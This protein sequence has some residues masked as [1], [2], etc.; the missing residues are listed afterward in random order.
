MLC[1]VQLISKH[2][3]AGT[4]L[5]DPNER[6]EQ[7]PAAANKQAEPAKGKSQPQSSKSKPKSEAPSKD[8]VKSEAPSKPKVKSEVPSKPQAKL[9]KR[10]KEPER[11]SKPQKRTKQPSKPADGA[12]ACAHSPIMLHTSLM[13]AFVIS[14]LRRLCSIST[15]NMS[16]KALKNLC[17]H[18]S[19]RLSPC[20]A[21][22]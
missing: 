11:E 6:Q 20:I 17:N 8:K 14:C 10:R 18:W 7:D 5:K 22:S 3:A 9:E 13:E 16:L 4:K 12:S 15:R 1:M 21:A 19:A 2:Q